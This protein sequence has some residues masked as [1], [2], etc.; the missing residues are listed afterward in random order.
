VRPPTEIAR[1]FWPWNAGSLALSIA[2][3]FIGASP[4]N[5]LILASLTCSAAWLVVLIV[6]VCIQ[7]PRALTQLVWLPGAAFWPG[8][9][10]FI[11]FYCFG[12]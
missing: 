9:W 6:A 4:S 5:G 11:S 8:L 2:A 1:V 3:F 12:C 10:L 7:G